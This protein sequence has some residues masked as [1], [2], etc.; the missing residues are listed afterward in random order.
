[1][2]PIQTEIRCCAGHPEYPTPVI[3]TTK[4][5]GKEFWCPFCGLKYEFFDGFKYYP[6]V[7]TLLTRLKKFEEVSTEYLQSDDGEY[8]FGQQPDLVAD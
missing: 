1:M 7:E 3:G 5:R 4:F 6:K 8:Q 2:F